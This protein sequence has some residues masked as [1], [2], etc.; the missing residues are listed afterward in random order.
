MRNDNNLTFPLC[1]GGMAISW[2]VS[3]RSE[4]QHLSIYKQ[5]KRIPRVVYGTEKR[6]IAVTFSDE[7]WVKTI[8]LALQSHN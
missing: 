7:N 4:R 6:E 2:V 8:L 3:S 1:E 5:D